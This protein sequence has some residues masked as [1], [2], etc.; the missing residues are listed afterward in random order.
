MLK[1][2]IS[3]ISFVAIVATLCVPFSFAENITPRGS[4]CGL[5]HGGSLVEIVSQ[6]GAPYESGR[7]VCSVNPYYNCPVMTQSYLHTLKC[8]R[9]HAVAETWQSYTTYVRHLH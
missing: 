7:P 1:K 6:N 4:A 3:V 9:C 8:N 5:C 2:F